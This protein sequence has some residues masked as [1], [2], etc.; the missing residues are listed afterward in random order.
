[1]YSNVALGTNPEDIITKGGQYVDP[2]HS[3]A[4]EELVPGI[5]YDTLDMRIYTKI[6][7]NAN[8]IAYRIFDNMIN[9]PAYYRISSANT[10][11]LSAN[12]SITDG[13]IYVTDASLLPDPNPTYARPGVIFINGERVTYYVKDLA[14]N[15]LGQIRRGTQGTG[16]ANIH[17]TGANVV[18][19]SSSEIL[20]GTHYANLVMYANVFYNPGSGTA[21]DGNGFNGSTEPAVL[22]MKAWPAS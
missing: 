21:T 1:M 18:A 19:A 14:N 6:N 2:Y 20:P 12:L 13:N 4:P 10:T 17:V 15:R 5:T 9:E 8:V 11:T 7:G 16:A 3:R 22:D